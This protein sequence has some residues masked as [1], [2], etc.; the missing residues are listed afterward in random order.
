MKVELEYF[1]LKS[2]LKSKLNSSYVTVNLFFRKCPKV[3]RIT[4]RLVRGEWYVMRTKRT[5]YVSGQVR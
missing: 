2:N 1:N 5:S 3:K 4:M